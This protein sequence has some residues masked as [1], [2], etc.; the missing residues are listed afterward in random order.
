MSA[1]IIGPAVIARTVRTVVLFNVRDCTR[2]E[3]R[4][5]NNDQV[6]RYCWLCLSRHN[7]GASNNTSAD[8]SAGRHDH[9]GRCRLRRR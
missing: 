2:E 4:R 6:D 8:P 3:N 5:Q 1:Q 7:F 9:A